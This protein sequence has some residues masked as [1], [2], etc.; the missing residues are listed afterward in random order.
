MLA[1]IYPEGPTMTNAEMVEA[2]GSSTREVFSMMLG[3]DV[4][5]GEP[6]VGQ[7]AGADTGVLALLGLAGQWVGTGSLC[8]SAAIACR[9]ASLMLMAEYPALNDEVLDAVAE[10][11]NMVVG[12][13]KTKLEETLG[14]MALSTPTVVYG[15]NFATRRVGSTEWVSV[16][17]LCEGGTVSVQVCLAQAS[18]NSTVF[19]PGFA[20]PHSVEL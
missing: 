19:R 4:T 14:A 16:P 2:I 9:L 18:E 5:A 20:L 12:N 1:A 15:R 8:C 13:I 7:K 10:L 3:I 17:F 6:F 11:A